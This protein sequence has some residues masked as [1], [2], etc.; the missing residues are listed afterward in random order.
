M[1][2]EKIFFEIYETLWGKEEE[3]YILEPMPTN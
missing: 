3:I 2:Y 1:R